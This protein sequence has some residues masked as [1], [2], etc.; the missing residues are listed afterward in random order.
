MRVGR[1]CVQC[2][3]VG[4]KERE[5]KVGELKSEMDR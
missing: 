4:N 3:I 1:K 2:I 5:D